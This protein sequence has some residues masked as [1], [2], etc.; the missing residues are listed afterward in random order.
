MSKRYHITPDGPK[1]CTA[2]Q[3]ACQYGNHYT[4]IEEAQKAMD[5]IHEMEELC[6]E[7]DYSKPLEETDGYKEYIAGGIKNILQVQQK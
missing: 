2:T 1:P 4:D 5:T 7:V 6:L 3:K